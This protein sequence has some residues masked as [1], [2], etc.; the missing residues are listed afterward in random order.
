MVRSPV[1]IAG[2]ITPWNL[3]LYL[4]SFKIAPALAAGCCAV[5]KPSE[6]TSVTA[7]MFCDVLNQAGMIS[8][9]FTLLT[10]SYFFGWKAGNHQMSNVSCQYETFYPL[11]GFSPVED[12]N[13]QRLL[14]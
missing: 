13:F 7:W 9:Y 14:P 8:D 3:P 2:L 6:M 11:I 10:L 12:A 4:L 5:V 1:G